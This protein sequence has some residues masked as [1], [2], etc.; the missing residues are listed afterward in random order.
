MFNNKIKK[1][2]K[3]IDKAE[4]LVFFTGAGIST[5]SGIPDFRSSN[6]ATSPTL[7]LSK[8][9]LDNDPELFFKYYKKRLVFNNVEPNISHKYMARLPKNNIVITQNIDGLHKRA[10]SKNILELHG[11]SHQNY[12]MVCNEQYDLEYIINS[13]SIIPYCEKCNSLI[14][15]PNIVRP[16]IV[17]YEEHLDQN[18]INIA[19]TLINN[20]DTLIICGTSLVVNPAAQLITLFEGENLVILNKDKTKYDSYADLVINDS[21][22]NV[23]SKLKP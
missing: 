13:K 15:K 18:K 19:S 3:I 7:M 11:S 2:Q 17:L 4:N 22:G 14:V 6:S 23:F 9:M 8:T 12:C 21:L 16:N 10:G 1:L 5:E 20:A